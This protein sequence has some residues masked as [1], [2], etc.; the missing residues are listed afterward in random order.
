MTPQPNDDASLPP[1]FDPFDPKDLASVGI[2]TPPFL[3]PR[4][5]G[6]KTLAGKAKSRANAV[7]HGLRYQVVEPPDQREKITDRVAEWTD[8]MKPTD[9]VQR[10]LVARAATASVRLDRCVER[11]NLALEENTAK[12]ERAFFR[13]RRAWARRLGA[14][15]EEQTE[16]AY[17]K[18][19]SSALGCD[20]LIARLDDLAA[21]LEIPGGYW[22]RDEFFQALRLL[23]F[24]PKRI[25][26]GHPV[27][28]R[29]YRASLAADKAPD[30]QEV[31]AF[32]KLDTAALDPEARAAEQRK[33]LGEREKGRQTLLEIV[34]QEQRRLHDLRDVLW[35][36]TDA[37]AL[38]QAVALAR[39]F[40]ASP[41]AALARR[42]E[43][44]NALEL[45]RHLSDFHRAR[46]EAE[47]RDAAPNERQDGKDCVTSPKA[48]ETSASDPGASPA[49]PERCEGVRASVGS[50]EEG[51][52]GGPRKPPREAENQ[53]GSLA[54]T[55]RRLGNSRFS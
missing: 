13:R 15:L 23:G 53:G 29:L 22:S 11:E 8:A 37:P 12:V 6:P 49:S 35:D 33:A 46:R 44:A 4:A 27:V 24:E 14:R 30:P 1:D 38:E 18:L 26:P 50:G 52:L 34:R 40:D 41:E 32:L 21:D 2:P 43:S 28:G 3:Q 9:A 16:K 47:Q 45:H 17:S 48:K 5:T 10:W 54:E 31:D 42:Y 19:L 7:K 25:P 20:W 36:E 55:H 39:T 51:P